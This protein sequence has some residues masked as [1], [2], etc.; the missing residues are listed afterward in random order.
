MMTTLLALPV[1]WDIIKLLCPHCNLLK[2]DLRCWSPNCHHDLSIVRKHINCLAA[3]SR[4]CKALNDLATPHLYHRPY[5]HDSGYVAL[6]RTIV[7]RP[8]LAH[9]VRHLRYE[10][11]TSIGRNGAP[12]LDNLSFDDIRLF[13]NCADSYAI[14]GGL[15]PNWMDNDSVALP[16][17]DAYA[18]GTRLEREREAVLSALMVARCPNLEELVTTTRFDDEGFFFSRPGSL[19]RL[20]TLWVAHYDDEFGSGF[21]NMATLLAAAPNLSRVDARQIAGA[22]DLPPTTAIRE[23]SLGDSN[24]EQ[25]DLARLLAACPQLESFVYDCNSSMTQGFQFTP[26]EA[27]ETLV[28]S[29]CARKLRVLHMDLS[30]ASYAFE[31]PGDVMDSLASLKVLETLVLDTTCV[32]YSPSAIAAGGTGDDGDDSND[33]TKLVA[34]LPTSIRSFQLTA[35]A[36]GSAATEGLFRAAMRLA[37]AVPTRFPNLKT[38]EL[39]GVMGAEAEEPSVLFGAHGVA[40]SGH[41]PYVY[42]D[43]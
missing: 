3:L 36:E 9:H 15:A 32:Y 34:L 39:C 17:P 25:D 16:A 18:P 6:V 31:D 5:C 29:L 4:T 1:L 21:E 35:G 11:W 14:D 8:D 2:K 42:T 12:T 30:G 19:P 13:R 7:Q 10:E 26:H 41:R 23:L 28:T 20:R 33:D 24:L 22:D 43:C 27:Q 38:V 37:D 40:F